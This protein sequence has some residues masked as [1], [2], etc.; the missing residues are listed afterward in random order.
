MSGRLRYPR[1]RLL[2]KMP[3]RKIIPYNPALK[4][5]ARR[6]RK[7]GTLGEVLLW[8]ELKVKKLCSLSFYRQRPI[9]EYIVDFFCPEY[10]LAVEVDGSS[11]SF[12]GDED[13]ERQ[14]RLESLGVSF[15]RFSEEDVRRELP[16]VVEAIRYWL[17][18]R[19]A[20]E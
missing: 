8:N 1:H 11:H 6:L 3:R 4:P 7:E 10:M 2:P 16:A 13:L 20:L 15:L 14:A 18:E 9:D 5:L 12:R 19:Q 17:E